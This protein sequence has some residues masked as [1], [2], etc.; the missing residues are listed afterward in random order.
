MER[1]QPANPTRRHDDRDGDGQ[2]DRG[3]YKHEHRGG[4]RHGDRGGNKHEDRRGDNHNNRGDRGGDGQ[5]DRNNNR[6]DV[7]PRR[8]LNKFYKKPGFE[9][10]SGCPC[11]IPLKHPMT[12]KDLK[13]CFTKRTYHGEYR[14]L[15]TESKDPRIIAYLKNTPDWEKRAETNYDKMA[16]AGICKP[17]TPSKRY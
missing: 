8:Y 9:T 10:P 12:H 16:E 1:A 2:G 3:G 4:N 13:T 17:R 15:F 7:N 5:G 6:P 11:G 14:T